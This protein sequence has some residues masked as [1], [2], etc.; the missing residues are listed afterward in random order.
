MPGG[1]CGVPGGLCGVPAARIGQPSWSMLWI[2]WGQPLPTASLV[3]LVQPFGLAAKFTRC[4]DETLG[5][6]GRLPHSLDVRTDCDT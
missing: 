4:T 5:Q 6:L 1:L 2:G 3:I